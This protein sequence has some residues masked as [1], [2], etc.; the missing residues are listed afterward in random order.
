MY[1]FQYA[2]AQSLAD[3]GARLK[4]TDGAKLLAGGMT[5]LPT[6]KLR[7]ARPPALVD[8]GALGDLKGIDVSGGTVTIKAMTRHAD[9]ARSAAIAKAIPALV[10]LAGGIGDTQVRH[11]GTIGGSVANNDP[12]ADYPAGCLGLGAKIV[13][14]KREHAADDFFKALFTTAL[15]ADE[16]ITAIRF[17][18]PERAAYMKFKNPASRYAIVGAMV[19]KGPAGVR[20]AITGAG[21][22]GVFRVPAMEQA[23]GR[24][25]TPA[26][27]EGITMPAG[28]LMSDIHAS[29]EYRAHL[30]GV[31]VK[32]AVAACA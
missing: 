16:I 4:A 25:F 31:M 7:L 10:T 19:S 18:V 29:A 5:L 23:L 17:P 1:D 22:A 24:S 15:E 26:S 28:N 32:R 9:V 3:A 13:T 27:V 2:R 21:D 6:I 12:A 14:N 8:L 20:V 11:R 30:I